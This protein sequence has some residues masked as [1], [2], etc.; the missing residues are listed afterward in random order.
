[1]AEKMSRERF[2]PGAVIVR[3]GDPG[4]KFYMIRRGNVEV[5]VQDG[6]A[7]R[8]LRSMGEGEFFG[9][10]ALLTGKPRT[11]SVQATTAVEA[12]SLGQA[13][14]RSAVEASAS[15]KEQVLKILFQRQ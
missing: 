1:M 15:F 10:M 9:E 3:Q 2:P 5:L 7:R 11:A 13:D 14:F 6:E 8:V 4:D 12:Y